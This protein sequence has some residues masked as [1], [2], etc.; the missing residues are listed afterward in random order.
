MNVA[1]Q[2]PKKKKKTAAGSLFHDFGYI[3]TK[4]LYSI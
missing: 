1:M 2:E 3:R 4:T